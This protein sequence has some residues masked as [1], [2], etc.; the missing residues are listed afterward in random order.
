M[1]LSDERK[2]WLLGATKTFLDQIGGSPAEEYLVNHRGI[3][4]ETVERFRLGYVGDG[5]VPSGLEQ[6]RGCVAIPYLRRGALGAWSVMSIRFR[7]VRPEC[8]KH[9]DGSFRE[10]EIHVGH[11]KVQ[12]MAGDTHRIY[13][14]LAI[15]EASD[16][17]AV[18]EGEP[19]T[20]TSAQCG[21]PTVGIPGVSGWK[22]HFDKLFVGYR[23]VWVLAQ[24]D[25]AGQNFAEQVA[26]RI[27]S[28]L[29]VPLD[30]GLDVN[31]TF[32]SFGP[33][34]VLNKVGK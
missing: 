27:P 20:W 23:R 5:S 19:D 10:D 17:I 8:V 29:I 32:R 2:S 26:S 7:C 3:D 33:E 11:G 25:D 21:I 31:K 30:K 34:A 1:R 9:E 12:S 24:G 28:S 6:Y 4:P 15:Q 18:C 16:E 13:N 14:T 22:N